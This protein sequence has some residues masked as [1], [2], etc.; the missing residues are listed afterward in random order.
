MPSLSLKKSN[1]MGKKSTLTLEEKREAALA[2]LKRGDISTIAS[3]T[4][5]DQAHVSRVLR[6]ESNNPSGVIVKEAY[7]LVGKRKVKAS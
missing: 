1:T 2:R 6:G 5:Y 4:Y 3:N 7:R